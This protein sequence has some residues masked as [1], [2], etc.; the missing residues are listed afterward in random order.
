MI[1]REGDGERMATRRGDEEEGKEG[2]REEG[3]V[4][5]TGRKGEKIEKEGDG[6]RIATG[7]GEKEGCKNKGER[8][9]S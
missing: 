8:K 4:R 6:K 1:E 9:F 2:E 7:R 5:Q 3:I